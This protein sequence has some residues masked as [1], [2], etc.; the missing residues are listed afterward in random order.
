[1]ERDLSSKDEI[2]LLDIALTLWRKRLILIGAVLA[3]TVAGMLFASNQNVTYRGMLAIHPLNSFELRG[4]DLWNEAVFA[5]NTTVGPPNKDLYSMKV[6]SDLLLAEF[7]SS[8]L[9]GD[10]LNA[11]LNQH[12]EAVRAFEGDDEER[13]LLLNSLR[14]NFKLEI[15]E[16]GT[17][18][19][20]FHTT[21]RAES[22]KILSSTMALISENVKTEMLQSFHSRLEAID[23]ARQ[24]NLERISIEIETYAQLYAARKNRTLTIMREQAAIAR[25][26]GLENPVN[27]LP[28][29]P[30]STGII[31][32][33]KPDL[34][35]FGSRYFLQG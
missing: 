13:Q 32:F 6:T 1:M 33:V 29:E 26:L 9:R 19:I 23:L 11:A 12:S 5:E 20:S 2:D 30:Q 21:D 7:Q 25:R 28:N 18:A 4:F 8:Y 24:I 34:D 31:N 3:S 10:A 35:P 22:V 16:D 14:A 17:V 27:A 15:Q